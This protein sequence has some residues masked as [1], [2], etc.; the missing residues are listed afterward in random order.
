MPQ[1]L[2]HFVRIFVRKPYQIFLLDA[3]GA[4]STA[5]LLLLLV[6][7]LEGFFKMPVAIVYQ[8][9][10]AAGLFVL[11]SMACW[12]RKP[13]R[14]RPYLMAIIVANCLYCVLTGSLMLYHFDILSIWGIA[15]F[16]GEIVVIGLVVVLEVALLRSK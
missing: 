5:L 16:L 9:S 14:W 15:Y 4:L 7:P 12:L 11:Y 1:L 10:A 13:R 8:L 6:A 2:T 3:L